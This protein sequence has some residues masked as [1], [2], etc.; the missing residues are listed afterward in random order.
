MARA[1]LSGVRIWAA[2]AWAV[3][4]GGCVSPTLPLPPPDAP[5]QI[6]LAADGSTWAIRGSCTPGAVVLVKNDATGLISGV[7]DV[8]RDGRYLVD[9]Q[10]KPC[11]IGEVWE[12]IGDT[13]STATL[14]YVE[15]TTNGTPTAKSCGK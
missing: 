4:A 6:T 7:V 15:P 1:S 8:D 3:V 2:I 13:A 9:I 11:D 5:A 14:F 12:I 10:A